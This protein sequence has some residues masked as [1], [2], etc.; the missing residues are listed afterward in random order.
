[1]LS[2]ATYMYIY[3]VHTLNL[4]FVLIINGQVSTVHDFV[5]KR[6]DRPRL[7]TAVSIPLSIEKSIEMQLFPQDE[8]LQ[9]Q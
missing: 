1:M 2:V 7:G 8:Y 9:E 3:D 6:R 4:V 5:K